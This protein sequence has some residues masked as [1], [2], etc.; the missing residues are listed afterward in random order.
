MKNILICTFIHLNL[1]AFFKKAH[2]HAYPRTVTE[3]LILAT[4]ASVNHDICYYF[5][6]YVGRRSIYYPIIII[7]EPNNQQINIFIRVLCCLRTAQKP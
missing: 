2:K 3:P 6:E 5:T 7:N 4:F 1:I